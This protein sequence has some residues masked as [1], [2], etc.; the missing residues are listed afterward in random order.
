MNTVKVLRQLID[1]TFIFSL[2]FFFNSCREKEDIHESKRKVKFYQLWVSNLDSVDLKD[3]F[4]LSVIRHE[5]DE[6]IYFEAEP[7]YFIRNDS[8]FFDDTFC[9]TF[10]TMQ[11]KLEN[12]HV[13]L[14]ISDFDQERSADEESYLF[15]NRE[16]GVVAQYNWSMGPVILSEPESFDGLSDALYRYIVQ[17]EKKRYSKRDTVR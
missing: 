6:Q 10:D 16:L 12:R 14:F 5:N 13:I 4:T 3:T 15:W 8:M 9:E 7:A 17:R 1:L 11:L 2:T